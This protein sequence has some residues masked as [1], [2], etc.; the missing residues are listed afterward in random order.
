MP[1]DQQPFSIKK[2]IPTLTF[3]GFIT[4]TSLTHY[5]SVSVLLLIAII[6]AFIQLVL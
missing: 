4:F 1:Q 2:I 3:C 6:A 5:G